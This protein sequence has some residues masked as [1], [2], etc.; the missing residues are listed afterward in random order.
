MAEDSEL[1][2]HKIYYEKTGA[3]RLSRLQRDL[4][5]AVARQQWRLP[6]LRRRKAKR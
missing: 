6:Q 1:S 5:M 2:R 4:R 3:T